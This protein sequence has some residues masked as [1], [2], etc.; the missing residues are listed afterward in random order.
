MQSDR[1]RKRLRQPT[2]RPVTTV[3][4]VVSHDN[5]GRCCVQGTFYRAVDSAHLS[6]ALD[7]SRRPGRYSSA[8]Q[9]TLYLSSSRE[10]VAAAMAAHGGMRVDLF[11]LEVDV[12]AGGI[13]DLRDAWSLLATGV[14]LQDA[15]PPWQQVVA[16]G[17]VP[18]SWGV[19]ARLESLGANG[20]VDPSRTQPGLWHLV[21]FRWNTSDAPQVIPVPA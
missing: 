16:G 12:H 21:L 10:G 15:I 8:D 11:V 1:G 13:V 3:E 9:S 17:G 20:L 6:T 5:G 14:D 2:A 19:R 4:P 7:G 18:R